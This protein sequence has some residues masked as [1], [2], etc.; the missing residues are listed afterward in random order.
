MAHVTDVFLFQGYDREESLGTPKRLVT[1]INSVLDGSQPACV[2]DTR[3]TGVLLKSNCIIWFCCHFIYILSLFDR[4]HHCLILKLSIRSPRIP[5]MPR[6]SYRVYRPTACMQ[7][8]PCG[9][10]CSRV[11]AVPFPS[12]P[13]STS[14]LQPNS[15]WKEMHFYLRDG[16]ALCK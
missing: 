12:S 11:R 7:L 13:S 6:V 8:S 2:S 5:L 1:W 15:S 16:V 4:A 14:S 9:L 3:F 10:L